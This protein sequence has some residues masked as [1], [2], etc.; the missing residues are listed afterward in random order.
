MGT[1]N[2]SENGCGAWVALCAH[3]THIDADSSL[4][5]KQVETAARKQYGERAFQNITNETRQNVAHV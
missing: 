4:F 1:H 2:R 3:R 5:Y